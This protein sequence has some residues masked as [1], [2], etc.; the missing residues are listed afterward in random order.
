MSDGQES[1]IEKDR[2]TLGEGEEEKEGE[3]KFYRIQSKDIPQNVTK[4]EVYFK[5]DESE[6]LSLVMHGQEGDLLWAGP[7]EQSDDFIKY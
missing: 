7:T 1:Q 2:R 6:I 3:Y 5:K 4:I